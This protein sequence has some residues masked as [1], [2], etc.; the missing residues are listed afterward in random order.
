MITNAKFERLLNLATGSTLA[1][2][3]DNTGS[4]REEIGAVKDETILV[5]NE[6]SNTCFAPSQYI[7]SPFNDPGLYE[8][9]DVL[10]WF[11]PSSNQYGIFFSL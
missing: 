7:V 8:V 11:K 10:L 9:S 2:A 5:V 6:F 1:F 3:I 4:M